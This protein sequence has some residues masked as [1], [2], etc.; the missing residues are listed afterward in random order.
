METSL[1]IIVGLILS[2]ISLI[3]NTVEVIILTREWKNKKPKTNCRRLLASL[4]F[5]DLLVTISLIALQGYSLAS[6][7]TIAGKLF[8]EIPWACA[9]SPLLHTALISA[10]RFL[11]VRF[12]VKHKIQQGKMAIPVF[13]V[14]IWLMSAISV[15]P[16]ISIRSSPFLRI[17]PASRIWSA[18]YFYVFV[19]NF[20]CIIYV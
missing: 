11:M 12:P 19:H 16:F 1:G 18:Y 15:L 20:S 9:T 3:F 7:S 10:D 13:I 4:A 8:E 2:V 5:S 14:S 17:F 6:N